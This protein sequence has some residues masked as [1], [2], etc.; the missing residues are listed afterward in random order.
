MYDAKERNT[1]K[2]QTLVLE[3]CPEVVADRRGID[4]AKEKSVH[5]RKLFSL[6]I[7]GRAQQLCSFRLPRQAAILGLRAGSTGAGDSEGGRERPG[8]SRSDERGGASVRAC[9][10][11]PEECLIAAMK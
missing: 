9:S 4:F 1:R 2:R 10:E 6:R 11:G 8:A 5:S 7:W 3:R